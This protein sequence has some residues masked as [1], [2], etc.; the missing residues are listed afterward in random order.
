M[1][2]IDSSKIQM[3]LPASPPDTVPPDL[4]DD[5]LI[6]YRAIQNLLRGTSRYSGIDP[7]PAEVWSSL[8]FADT[9]LSGNLTRF[10]V[11][12]S[13]AISRGQVINLHNNAGGL[14]ARLAVATSATTMA[15]GVANTSAAVGELVEINWLRG[16]IDSIGGMTTGTLYWLSTV[17]GGVQNTAPAVPG[18]IQQPIG[19]AF[20]PAQMALDIPLSYRQL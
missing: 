17:A 1:T 15:H 16:F 6:V 18:Q 11:P 12:A 14:N 8:V 2:A 3:G 4:Y 9:M 7:E 19:V 13:V 5:F 20:S 10:Y